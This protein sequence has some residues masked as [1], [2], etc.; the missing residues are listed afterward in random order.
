MLLKTPNAII[1]NEIIT[2]D[3]YI[4]LKKNNKSN[5]VKQRIYDEFKNELVFVESKERYISIT[6]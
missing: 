2:I 1:N 3:D 6:F 4:K 5:I